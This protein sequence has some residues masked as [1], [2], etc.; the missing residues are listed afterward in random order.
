M[1]RV[2]ILLLIMSILLFTA[3]NT[4]DE[5]SNP[6]NENEGKITVYTSFS[7]LHDFAS[8][9]GGEYAQ[10]INMIPQGGDPHH[11]EPTA[12][13]IMSL[14]EAD[15]FI[16][17]G[18]SLEHWAENVLNSID[19]EKLIVL[20]ASVGIDLLE[21]TH[22]DDHDDHHHHGEMDPHIWLD[23]IRAKTMFEN[24]KNTFIEADP[25][26]E[27]YYEN[28]YIKY[29]KELDTLDEEYNKNLKDLNNTDMVVTHEAFTYLSESYNLNQ[30]G[31][32]GLIP[33]SEPSPSR[34]AEI[35]DYINDNDIKTIFFE[36]INDTK[37]VET[38]SKET[39]VDM[40]TLYTLESLTDEQISN[41]DDYFSIMRQNLE[42]LK[43]GLE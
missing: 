30:I 9:I 10:V 36:D 2:I 3:C 17:N 16:Y 21:S 32:E 11:W 25:D 20:E 1:K 4:N 43:T 40:K 38:I 31:I 37:V 42:S 29:A 39:G 28:N 19:N 18:L 7:V 13:D 22:H 8:K 33:D 27:E 12:S 24:I 41:D 6:I 5:T 15:I 14:E 35:I 23:P 26:N 34:M